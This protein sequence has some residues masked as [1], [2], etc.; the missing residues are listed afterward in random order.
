MALNV[1]TLIHGE[2]Q[3]PGG[4]LRCILSVNR[5]VRSTHNFSYGAVVARKAADPKISQFFIL[6]LHYLKEKGRIPVEK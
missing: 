1:L 5:Q 6:L 2:Q 3:L 4:P